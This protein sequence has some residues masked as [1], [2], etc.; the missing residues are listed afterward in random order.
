LQL[1]LKKKKLTDLLTEGDDSISLMAY[2]KTTFSNE[3]SNFKERM[4]SMVPEV[5]VKELSEMDFAPGE[6]V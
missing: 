6:R 4:K 2:L 5:D 3:W 1:G